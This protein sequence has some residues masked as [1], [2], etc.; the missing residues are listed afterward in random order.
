MGQSSH[1]WTIAIAVAITMA[2]GTEPEAGSNRAP[3][4]ISLPA[5]GLEPDSITVSGLS[6]GAFM[7]V[8]MQVAHSASVKGAA[9]FSGGPFG[10]ARGNSSTAT[11]TEAAAHC[12]NIVGMPWNPVSSF[13]GP[14][15]TLALMGGASDLEKQGKID[16]LSNI[17]SHH[18]FLFSGTNDTVIPQ[19]VMIALKDWYAKLMPT[20]HIETLFDVRAGHGI[21]SQ[22][23]T[24][25]CPDT[26]LPYINDCKIDGAGKAL[27]FLLDETLQPPEEKDR[28]SLFSFPQR[29]FVPN[30]PTRDGLHETG[31][32]FIPDDCTAGEQCRLHIAFHGCLQSQFFIGDRFF[33]ETGYNRWAASNRIVVLY[34]Q[35]SASPLYNPAGCWDWWGYTNQDYL[36]RDGIQIRSVQAMIDRLTS[37][38][39]ES[40]RAVTPGVPKVTAYH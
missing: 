5:L 39:R 38:P 20:S 15:D 3:Q 37:L 27:A 1:L 26:S 11:L 32:V 12:L 8:Q 6:S 35:V 36:N 17:G 22:Q 25:P 34:P 2:P 10:C 18:V 14:P 13:M 4:S 21:L 16:A 24:V 33:T 9:V 40:R 29:R 19:P 31:H 30:S 7:A 28:G 23:G